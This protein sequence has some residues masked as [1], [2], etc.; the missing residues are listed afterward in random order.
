MWLKVS[1]LKMV[2]LLEALLDKANC[3]SPT[4]H[5]ENKRVPLITA[6]GSLHCWRYSLGIGR[7][8]PSFWICRNSHAFLKTTLRKKKIKRDVVIFYAAE[9]IGLTGV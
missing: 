9:I 8:W 4:S 1:T 7:L 3:P 5:E 6:F 2:P